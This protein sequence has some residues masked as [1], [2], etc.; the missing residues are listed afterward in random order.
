[1]I[2]TQSGAAIDP[3][4]PR[5]YE[6]IEAVLKHAAELFPDE[7]VHLGGDEVSLADWTTDAR[8]A[9]YLRTRYPGVP[10]NKAAETEAYGS[11]TNRLQMMAAKYQKKVI[12]WEGIGPFFPILLKLVRTPCSE[13]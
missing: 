6:V 7:Y 12:H 9:Q 1:M 4:A 3:S 11:F 5:L 2:C 13:A 10:L 8:V